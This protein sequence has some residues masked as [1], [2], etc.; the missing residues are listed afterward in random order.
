MWKHRTPKWLTCAHNNVKIGMLFHIRWIVIKDR[1]TNFHSAQLSQ[2]ILS[3]EHNTDH[4]IWVSYE[5]LK[6]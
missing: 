2:I 6:L 3:Q 1:M 5:C 4:N